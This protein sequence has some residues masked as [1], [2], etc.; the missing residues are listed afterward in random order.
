[1][2]VIDHDAFS[3]STAGADEAKPL[4]VLIADDERISRTLLM[5]VV[6]SWGYETVEADSGNK[7]WEL[8]NQDE[9][10]R[11]AIIDWMM[12]GIDGVEI[13]RRLYQRSGKPLIYTI[14]L[15]SKTDES[16]LIYALEQGAHDFQTKPANPGEL[17]ARLLVGKRFVEADDRLNE[18][19][20]RVEQMAATDA[21]T[22]VANRR[23][24]FQLAERELYRTQR[25]QTPVALLVIDIDNFK[26]I[27]DT[28]GHAAGDAALCHLVAVC[29]LSLRRT[30]II[31]RFGGDEFI[32]LLPECDPPTALHTAERLRHSIYATPVP[33]KEQ[34]FQIEVTIGVATSM[35]GNYPNE[36]IE[37]LLRLADEA[38]YEG[39]EAGRNRVAV[40][41]I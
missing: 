33:E 19:L 22:G 12:P 5:R 36:D 10:P 15:T 6:E 13:C 37:T 21:L 14:L 38:L 27:N 1:M 3:Q 29:Q 11:I 18:S 26:E 40:R 39:K 30:D 34:A 31:A 23:H 17:R 24:F 8:L 41:S 2:P 20:A 7:A 25:T 28:Y 4:R 9:P 16:A 35:G 32:I